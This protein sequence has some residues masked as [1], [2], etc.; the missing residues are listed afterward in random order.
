MPATG[1]GSSSTP[2][3]PGCSSFS[4]T[5]TGPTSAAGRRATAD[6]CTEFWR[7]AADA[8]LLPDGVDPASLAVV[9]DLLVCADTIVHLRRTR[10]WSAAGHRALVVDTLTALA[11]AR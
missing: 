6:L 2:A 8:G 3:G 11:G 1:T 5:P 4:S 7:R 9:T 10:Q